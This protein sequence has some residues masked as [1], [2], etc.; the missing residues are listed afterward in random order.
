MWYAIQGEDDGM[1]IAEIDDNGVS[2]VHPL[3]P[4]IS[5]THAIT[6]GPD[7]AVWF[8]LTV[9][10][11]LPRT[12]DTIPALVGGAGAVGRMTGDGH[13]EEFFL[14][15]RTQQPDR[16]TSFGGQLWLTAYIADQQSINPQVLW[17]MSTAGVFTAATTPVQY[18]TEFLDDTGTS[19]GRLWYAGY[20]VGPQYEVEDRIGYLD[21]AG[22]AHPVPLPDTLRGEILGMVIGPD[23]DP[24]YLIS[25]PS[26]ISEPIRDP[27]IVRV[28]PH[29]TITVV[30]SVR[31]GGIGAGT[32]VLVRTTHDDV[33]CAS[34]AD[35]CQ[36][37]A[38]GTVTTYDARLNH[39]HFTDHGIGSFVG[40]MLH[41]VAAAPDGFLWFTDPDNVRI[42]RY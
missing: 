13:V 24:W 22:A 1:A 12:V 6:L 7:G 14:P 15:D 42:L 19:G 36:V 9:G 3:P 30:A 29:A 28:E 4:P 18:T 32:G 25:T 26:L 2:T 33:W 16:I 27:R 40:G 11:T 41:G 39:P 8:T 10:G 23:G 21:A 37:S 31:C 38:T 35:V 17:R 5:Q 34:A 20:L